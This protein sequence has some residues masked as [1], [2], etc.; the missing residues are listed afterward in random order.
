MVTRRSFRGF[1]KTH[2]ATT[3]P[4][5]N[6]KHT[7][8]ADVLTE[9]PQRKTVPQILDAKTPDGKQVTVTVLEKIGQGGMGQVFR[10]MLGD[11]DGVFKHVAVKFMYAPNENLVIRARRE[12]RMGLYNHPNLLSVVA[13]SERWQDHEILISEYIEGTDASRLNDLSFEGVHYVSES[14][15]KALDYLHRNNLIHRDVKPSN[16]LISGNA[17][18]VKLADFG[19]VKMIGV[20]EKPE[21]IWEEI[22]GLN[23]VGT[24]EYMAPEQ[25]RD[26]SNLTSACDVFSWGALTYYLISGVSPYSRSLEKEDLGVIHKY[27]E[28]AVSLSEGT[29]KLDFSP[30]YAAP[31][32]LREVVSC[33][34]DPNPDNR[35]SMREVLDVFDSNKIS[36]R[37]ARKSVKSA[38]AKVIP[39]NKSFFERMLQFFGQ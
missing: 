21:D 18:Y 24:P 31:D 9:E 32:Y 36:V 12:Q 5:K 29:A 37:R 2:L 7:V 34:L 8:K 3:V 17:K 13:T 10:G 27:Y 6:H 16:V 33:A 38:L 20:E 19:T 30:L 22:T 23:L 15:A 26:S 4:A 14:I 1:S 28:L 11:E 39:N 25:V 35:P